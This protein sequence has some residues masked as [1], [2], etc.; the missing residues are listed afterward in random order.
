MNKVFSISSDGGIGLFESPTGTGKTLSLICSLYTWLEKYRKGDINTSQIDTST[1]FSSDIP[2]K[3]PTKRRSSHSTIESSTDI[4]SLPDLIDDALD[5]RNKIRLLGQ[6]DKFYI[7]SLPDWID[8]ALD[9][10]NKIRL[11]GQYDKFCKHRNKFISLGRDCLSSSS[12]SSSFPLINSFQ[13]SHSK[14]SYDI[15]SRSHVCHDDFYYTDDIEE[16]D[17][18]TDQEA[19][20]ISS[21][22]GRIIYSARTHTQLSQF[23]HEFAEFIQSQKHQ[24]TPTDSSTSTAPSTS[25]ICG[26]SIV[27]LA[28]R[29]QVCL[30]DS[31]R[32]S[33]SPSDSCKSYKCKFKDPKS[34]HYLASSI[35]STPFDI[36]DV[37]ENGKKCNACP[38]YSLRKAAHWADFIAVPH[39]V[40]FSPSATMS[41]GVLPHITSLDISEK[42]SIMPSHIHSTCSS[43]RSS[44]RSAAC[45]SSTSLTSSTLI[46]SSSSSI[47]SSNS[48]SV[49][50]DPSIPISFVAGK[51]V[52]Y[53][54]DEAHNLLSHSES[55]SLSVRHLHISI[56]ACI[57][58]LE[59]FGHLAGG[60]K[61]RNVKQLLSICLRI[62]H[63]F[64]CT[65]K[66]SPSRAYS[67][68]RVKEL[69]LISVIE[70]DSKFRKDGTDS[71]SKS[72]GHSTVM[73]EE[74]TLPQ[75]VFK[76]SNG[77]Y[78]TM[79]SI[80]SL[81]N[82]ALEIDLRKYGWELLQLGIHH[83]LAGSS[84]ALQELMEKGST[85]EPGE[86]EMKRGEEEKREGRQERIEIKLQEK[87]KGHK[88]RERVGRRKKEDYSTMI[89]SCV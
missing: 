72:S 77:V 15:Q 52:V 33:F 54:I 45:T 86:N 50:T 22:C 75:C 6:Y 9:D 68:S 8:D 41:L 85:F 1:R 42:T 32:S 64:G 19:L 20:V 27:P 60:F 3:K 70:S 87:G 37:V 73:F 17:L 4:P 2:Q 59:K 57:C 61:V 66:E 21:E 28:S 7:P 88:R 29:Q 71:D 58:W 40:L 74:K 35:L 89:I 80:I 78:F 44:S 5:D 81:L 31:V 12:S 63:V 24:Q 36:E 16:E 38:Y 18:L 10:R 76:S 65:P 47:S 56:D 67:K 46:G 34:I 26:I 79:D 48:V 69:D 53:A 82:I 13:R 39:A 30:V 11:L 23:V 84:S 14:H 62:C 51:G 55:C 43:I 49:H 25:S 83:S